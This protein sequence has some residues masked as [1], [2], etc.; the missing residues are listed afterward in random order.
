MMML[1]VIMFSIFKI[2]IIILKNILKLIEWTWKWI[3]YS[4]RMVNGNRFSIM[5]K[6]YSCI[7]KNIVG[8]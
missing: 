8:L 6:D 2:G 3:T 1:Y 5:D 7:D 4:K